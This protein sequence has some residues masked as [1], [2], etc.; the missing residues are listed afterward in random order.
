MNDKQALETRIAKLSAELDQ[1]DAESAGDLA[2][3]T[4]Q[5]ILNL[6]SHFKNQTAYIN[7]EILQT[8]RIASLRREKKQPACLNASR[9]ALAGITRIMIARCQRDLDQMEQAGTSQQ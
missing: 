4:E 3:A 1:L 7:R 9:L 8:R 5:Q 6:Y 2:D